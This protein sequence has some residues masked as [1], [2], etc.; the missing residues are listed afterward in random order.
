MLEGRQGTVAWTSGF[1]GLWAPRRSARNSPAQDSLRTVMAYVFGGLVLLAC[2]GCGSKVEESDALAD[3]N[4]AWAAKNLPPGSREQYVSAIERNRR[5]Q[6]EFASGGPPE[7]L[8]ASEGAKILPGS[9][10][11]VRIDVIDE[12]SDTLLQSR[13]LQLLVPTPGTSIREGRYGC[14]ECRRLKAAHGLNFGSAGSPNPPPPLIVHQGSPPLFPADYFYGMSVGG[15][16]RLRGLN[17]P[18]QTLHGPVAIDVPAP[19]YPRKKI[20]TQLTILAACRADARRFHVTFTAWDRTGW[21]PMYK[22]EA[23]EG[24]TEFRGCRPQ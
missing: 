14:D 11:D 9:M 12:S 19:T 21:V 18:I 10:V 20:R 13:D 22:G 6:E 23:M 17:S 8:V 5:A 7:V 2:S 4:Q 1:A 16:Y 24:W 3:E 15:T